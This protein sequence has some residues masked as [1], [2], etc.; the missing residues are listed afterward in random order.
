MIRSFALSDVYYRREYLDA[1]YRRG[2]GEPILFYHEGSR[3]RGYHAAMMRSFDQLKIDARPFEDRVD[4]TTPYGYGGPVLEPLDEA[5]ASDYDSAW[6]AAAKEFGA[7]SEFVRFHPLFANHR[8][9]EKSMN[10]QNTSRTVVMD[11]RGQK[12]EDGLSKTCRKNYRTAKKKGV[13]VDYAKTEDI[14]RFF[15]LYDMTME[16][17]GARKYYCFDEKYFFDLAEGLGGDLW[18]A[19]AVHE[20][21]DVAGALILRHGPYI[22]YHLGGSDFARRSLCATNLL[23]VRVAERAAEEG[24][25]HFH[26]GGGYAGGD[27]IFQFKSGFS[28]ATLPFYQGRIIHDEKVYSVLADRAG[29]RKPRSED[30][31][32]IYRSPGIE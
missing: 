32:P 5:N 12:P 1:L 2:E 31:F 17:R 29:K 16:R 28:S 21:D 6:N 26:L 23:L 20:G 4:F 24:L 14:G 19:M 8:F 15:R 13:S 30:Y 22:H 9:M 18:I 27:G 7:V 25:T 3:G 10:A 11:L